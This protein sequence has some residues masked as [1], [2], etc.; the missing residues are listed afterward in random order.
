VINSA[1]K[2]KHVSVV[3][4]LPSRFINRIG[5][6][7]QDVQLDVLST[8]WLLLRRLRGQPCSLLLIH[9]ELPDTTGP[10]LAARVRILRSDLPILLTTDRAD[11]PQPGMD[12]G[13]IRVLG[14][15]HMPFDW[16]VL[17]ERVST[18]AQPVVQIPVVPVAHVASAQGRVLQG[19]DR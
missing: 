19:T 8:G 2:A 18:V 5:P 9:W 3:W 1:N 12:L 16:S 11:L 15:L 17:L 13:S 10:A 14:P 6:V 4:G 7:P